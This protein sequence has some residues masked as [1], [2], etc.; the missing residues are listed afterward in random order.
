MKTY[1]HTIIC[2]FLAALFK[3]TGNWKQ[4]KS[5]SAAYG[6]TNPAT[7]FINED[8]VD[9]EMPWKLSEP[10]CKEKLQCIV[11]LLFI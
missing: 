10:L 5:V 7:V 3:I 9:Y 4:P 2:L 8:I 6:E 1:A 11:Q